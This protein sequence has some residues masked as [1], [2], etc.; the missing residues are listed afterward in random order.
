MPIKT[1]C[2]GYVVTKRIQML[3][4]RRS[5][6]ERRTDMWLQYF[7]ALLVFLNVHAD[8]SDSFSIFEKWRLKCHAK[9]CAKGWVCSET[10]CYHFTEEKV[11]F[12]EAL[13]KCREIRAELVEVND[14]EEFQFLKSQGDH[15]HLPSDFWIALTDSFEEGKWVWMNTWNTASFKKWAPGQPDDAGHSEDCVHMCSGNS[16]KWN[17]IPCGTTRQFVCEK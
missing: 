6:K 12:T 10:S 4:R 11:T 17:D 9:R 3:G 1:L 14:E 16:F 13:R 15:K 5:S 2:H 7:L 8:D